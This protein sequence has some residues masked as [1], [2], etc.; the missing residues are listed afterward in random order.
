MLT[1]HCKRS[2]CDLQTEQEQLSAS[3]TKVEANKI[4]AKFEIFMF[5][6]QCH[7]ENCVTVS[8]AHKK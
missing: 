8:E 6:I 1:E 5:W 2:H 7:D 4:I 3:F